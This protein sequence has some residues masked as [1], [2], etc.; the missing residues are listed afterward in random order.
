V[1]SAL[2]VLFL[3]AVAGGVYA[4]DELGEERK[5]NL[6]MEYSFD[7]YD[8][9]F[10]DAENL[11]QMSMFATDL[12]TALIDWGVRAAFEDPFREKSA[13]I[14][15]GF[16][17]LLANYYDRAIAISEHEEGHLL[18]CRK[19]GIDRENAVFIYEDGHQSRTQSFLD[20]FKA[21]VD[22]SWGVNG[23][24]V[25]VD[26]EG[27]A[28]FFSRPEN[29]AHFH[30]LM[31]SFEA[32]GLNQEQ[33][34]LRKRN[35]RILSGEA[36]VLDFAPWLRYSI[37]TLNYENSDIDDYL[38][39]LKFLGV[40][41]SV[42]HVKNVQ[43]L[44]FAGASA[45]T[46]YAGIYNFIADRN[47]MVRPLGVPLPDFAS[48]LSIHGPTLAVNVTGIALDKLAIEPNVQFA[49]DDAKREEYGLRL[50]WTGGI[51]GLSVAVFLNRSG[52]NWVD[53][54]AFFRPTEWLE[55][56]VGGEGG[57]GFTFEREV[58]GKTFTFLESREFHPEL[59]IGINL[60]F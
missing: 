47:P 14:F 60:R 9:D 12:P 19:A 49:I 42:G 16:V 31:A 20:T 58:S 3:V 56:G 2:A 15:F 45:I 18:Q 28:E 44:K 35:E 21:V 30:E 7:L 33:Y 34:S 55:I 11:S 22:N 25:S 26:R 8:P 41:S 57:R 32:G 24:S 5:F 39:E 48:F 1:K 52:G 29:L 54:K 13:I 38:H 46:L 50:K 10:V 53:G 23:V 6:R 4:Q 40:N 17:R 36:H 51:F 59:S 27:W 43:W 37:A